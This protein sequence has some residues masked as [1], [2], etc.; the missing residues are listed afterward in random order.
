MDDH[1]ASGQLAASPGQRQ[2]RD[3]ERQRKLAALRDRLHQ[4]A[5]AVRT[6]EDWASCLRLA[7]RLPGE[8]FANILLIS[9]Q[10]PGATLVRD[11]GAWREIGR[12]VSRQEKGIAI[13]SAARKP[14]PRHR[15]PHQDQEPDEPDPT[16][17]DADRVGY[18]WDLA[19]TSGPAV[20][21]RAAIPPPPGDAPP[22]VWDAL[23]WMARREGFA[24]EREHGCPDDGVTMWAARR[25]RVLPGLD[26]Q[27]AA[28]AL[29]HQ[30]GHVLMHNTTRYPPGTTTSGCTGVRKAEADSVA[31]I[32]C[33]RHGITTGHRFAY[34]A[35]WAGSDP[36][37]HPEAAI[38]A[39]GERV[40]AAAARITRHLHPIL[41]G[42]DISLG[43]AARP[44]P[45]RRAEPRQHAAVSTADGTEAAP[46]RP[47]PETAARN[48][49]I[50]A[51]AQDFFTGQLPGSWAPAYLRTRGIGD[52]AIGEW[53]IGYAPGGWTALTDHLRG[54]GHDDDAIQAAGLARP[55]SRGTLI[56]HFR[57]RVMLPVHDEH[58]TLAGFTGRASPRSGPGVP[59]YLNS[60]ETAT[61]RKGDLLFGLH[62]ARRDLARGAVP[63][64]AEGPFD[65]IA[66]TIADPGRD[67]GLAPCG[68]ALTGRQAAALATAA[69]L[70][71]TGILVAFDD[72]LAGR[73]AAA[74]AYGILRPLTGKLQSALL[75]GKDPAEI[76]QHDGPAALRTVLREQV[77]PLSA[78][79][80]DT[81][82]GT[83]ERRLRD[84]DGPLLAMR[85]VATLIGGLLPPGSAGQ[86][87]Q[88]TG[89]REL[90]TTDDLLRPV[91]APELPEI[92][93]ILPADAAYQ[94]MR[95][96]DRLGFGL[97]DV[98][99][100][101]ANSIT[102][103][104]RSPKDGSPALRDDADRRQAPAAAA[105]R[106]AGS[107][108]PRPPP[109]PQVATRPAAPRPAAPASRVHRA[110]QRR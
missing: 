108:F 20:T 85:D 8:S 69:D 15:V 99:A 92:A 30:L 56:D 13:F 104:T 12:Q 55:S 68:T 109:A 53:G 6:P 44:V 90:T 62:R 45:E 81:R 21:I 29:A 110:R 46:A 73:K 49:R 57:D 10:Q 95:V 27:A 28:W 74:R 86:I 58:G 4:E 101:V 43:A 97:S 103:H 50:L 48:A 77:R 102:R 105:A 7:A 25:I 59:K 61:Y 14:A 40:T 5:Q 16:W 71:R 17:R 78:V 94:V 88:V 84:P 11:Y 106:L 96:A 35:T 26:G 2:E 37:A 63:V 47:D 98:L 65:A 76:L 3:E 60:P 72:D 51:D 24:V 107:S 79:I 31:F 89:D 67:A 39:A 41:P 23:C 19:Q 54:L 38:L 1:T 22:G 80:I 100:E 52:A 36:R 34:P 82:I 18:V 83:W 32:I 9:A 91:E 33:H 75:A 66:I 93:R 70:P 64:I 87:R 42:Q